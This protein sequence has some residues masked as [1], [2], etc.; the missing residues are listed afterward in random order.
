MKNPLRRS[1]LYILVQKFVKF[2]L[3]KRKHCNRC[4][5]VFWPLIG[6]LHYLECHLSTTWRTYSY[7]V[8]LKALVCACLMQ[9]SHCTKSFYVLR[10]LLEVYFSK[11]PQP[12]TW[13]N[14]AAVQF[15]IQRQEGKGLVNGFTISMHWVQDLLWKLDNVGYEHASQISIH[16]ATRLKLRLLGYIFR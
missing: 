7:V 13:S 2:L 9:S 14:M 8:L 15:G 10:N 1:K 12:K 16:G 6:E 3:P 11:H 4:N 5:G